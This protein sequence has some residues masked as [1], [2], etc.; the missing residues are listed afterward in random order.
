MAPRLQCRRSLAELYHRAMGVPVPQF[1]WAS[2]NP[3]L[4]GGC[5]EL[6]WVW[7]RLCCANCAALIAISTMMLPTPMAKGGTSRPL[8]YQSGWDGGGSLADGDW[9]FEVGGRRLGAFS[10]S[11]V[12]VSHLR[13]LAVARDIS[14]CHLPGSF[15]HA[16]S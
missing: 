1:Y 6:D 5:R 14:F 2:S 11:Q 9:G 4:S 16:L 7:W 8:A 12:A 3:L 15:L 13:P 10:P